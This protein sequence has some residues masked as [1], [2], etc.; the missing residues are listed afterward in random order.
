MFKI[1]SF[2]DEIYDSMKKNLI[3][4]QVEDSHGFNKLAKAVNYLNAAAEIFE[5]AGMVGEAFEI[6][7]VLKTFASKH[8]QPL[9]H[10][11]M[12]FNFRAADDKQQDII[13]KKSFV[14]MHEAVEYAKTLIDH[15]GP[16]DIYD[17]EQYLKT[18][19]DTNPF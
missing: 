12:V 16:I 15:Y 8:R 10:N 4:N 14:N 17:G 19:Y 3:A 5:D 9:A 1:N 2:E 11:E 13:R 6:T 18:V 7:E